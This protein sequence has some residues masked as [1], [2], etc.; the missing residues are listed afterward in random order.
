[1]S[2]QYN[3]ITELI[4]LHCYQFN[5][6]PIVI[7]LPRIHPYITTIYKVYPPRITQY[8]GGTPC[9]FQ[10]VPPTYW[11]IRGGYT[12]SDPGLAWGLKRCFRLKLY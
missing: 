10:G 1:M 6:E 9:K 8:M 5:Y 12:L 7:Y 4:S 2:H 11:V 3:N